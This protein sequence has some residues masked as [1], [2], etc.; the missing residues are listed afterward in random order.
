MPRKITIDGLARVCKAWR[1]FVVLR[2]WELKSSYREGL[3]IDRIDNDGNYC[4]ANCRWA[5]VWNILSTNGKGG[6]TGR[7]FTVDQF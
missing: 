3:E 6:S 2:D 7:D 5:K 1:S 4:P